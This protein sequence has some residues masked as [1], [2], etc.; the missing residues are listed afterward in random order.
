[1][2]KCLKWSNSE[3][4]KKVTETLKA[5]KVCV[6]RSD[7]I[8]G[9]L[10]NLS[11]SSVDKLNFIKK[12]SNTPYIIL[13]KNIEKAEKFSHKVCNVNVIN[14]VKKFWPGPLTVIL[15]A[16]KEVPD[17]LKALN[18]TVALRV[19]KHS[20]LQKV[21]SHFDGLLSTS[22]NISGEKPI[23]NLNEK[24]WYNFE[25]IDLFITDNESCDKNSTSSTILD[26]SVEPFKILRE[27]NLFQKIN[28][29]MYK[30]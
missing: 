29:L 19:P 11:K 6:G 10:T 16:N 2:E 27:G 14:I 13:V 21:L 4:V 18:G 24:D 15:S 9:F 22:A 17:H 7:T 23:N 8:N 28:R 20:G 26:C 3:H 30:N 12:R 1:M 25:N 5:G